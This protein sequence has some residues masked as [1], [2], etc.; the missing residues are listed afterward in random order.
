[1]RDLQYL[2]NT[3]GWTEADFIFQVGAGVFLIGAYLGCLEAANAG[4]SS[5]RM[6]WKESGQ[7]GPRP[8]MSRALWPTEVGSTKWLSYYGAFIQYLGCALPL[9]AFFFFQRT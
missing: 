7:E 3:R 4:L 6:A 9:C 2:T 1:M 8:K 5:D